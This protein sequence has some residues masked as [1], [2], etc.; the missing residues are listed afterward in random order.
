[1]QDSESD[2]DGIYSTLTD[3]DLL[4]FSEQNSDNQLNLISSTGTNFG[5][6]STIYNDQPSFNFDLPSTTCVGQPGFTFDFASATSIPPHDFF[7][8]LPPT[9]SNLQQEF[10]I[11]IDFQ[12]ELDKIYNETQA[13]KETE[14]ID[15]SQLIAGL[16]QSLQTYGIE[17]KL[18]STSDSFLNGSDIKYTS[19]ESVSVPVESSP[20]TAPLGFNLTPLECR[21]TSLQSFLEC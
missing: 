14:N 11:D 3:F 4:N 7:G 6:T 5:L 15:Y 12:S 20:T 17:P 21:M 8:N 18:N 9:T 13:Q 16:Q 19:S 2:F 1:M 10:N